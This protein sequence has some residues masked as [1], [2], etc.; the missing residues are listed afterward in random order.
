M[1]LP[2]RARTG[3]VCL[4]ATATVGTAQLAGPAA[5]EPPAQP[6]GS[7]AEWA[8]IR[9]LIGAIDD[10]YTEPPSLNAVVTNGYTAGLLLGNGDLAVTSDA[11]NRAQTLYLAKSDFWHTGDG[12]R[13][14]GKLTIKSPED[15]GATLATAKDTLECTAACA[16]DGDPETRWVSQTNASAAAPQW[17][18]VDLGAARRVDRWGVRHNGYQGRADNFQ[19]LNTQDFALQKSDDGRTWTDVDTVAGNT[20][21]ETDRQVAA[22]TARYVRLN[23]T[24]A[25][26]N[27]D[28]PN[29]KAYIRDLRLFDGDT[30]LLAPGDGGSDPE[31]HQKQDVLNAEVRGTQTMADQPVQTR[32]WTADGENLLVTEIWTDEDAER[33]P[34]QID[35][36]LPAGTVGTAGGGQVWATRTTGSDTS[37]DWVSRAAASAKVEG[38][39]TPV[40]AATPASDLARL[41]FDLLPGR[42]VRLVTSVHG[43]GTYANTTPVSA[44]TD[45]AV[46]RVRDI[47]GKGI[48][49]ERA[50]HRDWWK[51]YWLKSYVDTG[52]ATLNKYYYGALYAVGSASRAGNVPPGTYSPW[53]TADFVNLRNGY[54]LNYNTES[55]Y[56]GAYSANRPEL[57]EPY[58]RLIRA[59]LPYSRNRTHE[60][61]Y[62]GTTFRRSVLP[63][64]M[65]RSGPAE[66]PVAP[67]KDPDKLPSD[68]Q[69]NGTFAALPFLWHYEYTG[70]TKF[71]REVTYPFLKELGA[72]WADFV[73]KGED[74]K[75]DVLHSGVNEGGDDVNSVYDLGYIR[76]VMTAL[77]DGSKTLG[78]D[79][80][81]RPKWQE[82]LD[83][84]T[85]YPTGQRDGLDV[86]LLAEKI[87][88]P[89]KGNALLNKNDQPI[90][91]EGVVHPSD[92]LA[93][94][95]DPEQLR[96]V[97]NTLAW[98]DPFLPGSRGSSGNGFP[99]TFTIAARAGWD[100]EDLIHKFTTVIEDLWRPN[101][102]VRQFG[103]GQ[104][105]SG[106]LEAVNSMMLQTY[107][108]VTRI[109]PNWPEARDAEFNRLRAK[110]AFVLSA[111]QR[112]GTVRGVEVTSDRGND[113]SLA[114]PWGDRSVRVVDD[115]GRRVDVEED[116]GVISFPTRAGKT[117]HIS[118]RGR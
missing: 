24:R 9:S 112:R 28:D 32:T 36:N 94:G 117:Y 41:S 13:H 39:P 25:V 65:T 71:F 3:L 16:V 18:T 21:E 105:T 73:V 69:T 49:A 107:Q 37:T 31:Y 19:K 72:F 81:L 47:G 53:R 6:R 97:R 100:A 64:N 74:G 109:F 61:G 93:I 108:G 111:E 56:Y 57:A 78:V 89:I 55:Q 110:G 29:Q 7:E 14:L 114:S 27:A 58:Y 59:E 103:G 2:R 99:K 40:T 79:A 75:Y 46:E 4:L 54:Y 95:G 82:V 76:R 77:I 45:Q 22:F 26:R 84:L 5:A 68:Q 67:V 44:F 92:N 80:G 63:F 96:L 52:D 101:L 62:E 48:D 30:D 34:L 15:A 86:I 88:N 33:M 11:R 83:N 20:A 102:T 17:I 118:A 104:E 50:A 70:D 51:R 113:F 106:A 43:N 10:S 1:R 91:L 8:E 87:E 38:S 115:R 42:R 60:A 98:V 12:Q 85:P 23:I 116:D 35:L 66:T 90:N